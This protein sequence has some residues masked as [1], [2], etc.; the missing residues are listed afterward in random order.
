M[1]HDA[2]N[3]YEPVDRVAC[4]PEVVLDPDFRS[5]EDDLRWCWEKEKV[6]G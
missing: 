6:F 5:L 3:L 4:Q 2:R 1:T